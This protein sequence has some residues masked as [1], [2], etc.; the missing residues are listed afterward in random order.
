MIEGTRVIHEARY[1]HPPE[2]VWQALTDRA[3]LAAW[4]MPNDFSPREGAR[5]RF[6]AR[7]AHAEP[8]ECEVLEIEPLRRLRARWMVAGQPTT[9]T[10]ELHVDGAE[11]VLRVEHEGLPPDEQPNFD[12]GWG[13]K[14]TTDL[15]LVLD[16][17]RDPADATSSA[18]G[19]VSHPAI[20]PGP[21]EST[22]LKSAPSDKS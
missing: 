21:E 14:F 6:D 3:E 8:F 13:T 22:K 4:L 18:E 17:A 5:F 19:L 9:V 15:G 1:P 16:G 11:T 10:F 2:R 12:G 7:P 20:S